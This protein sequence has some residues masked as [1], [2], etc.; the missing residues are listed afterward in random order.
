MSAD[1]NLNTSSF[2]KLSDN[3]DSL[4]IELSDAGIQFCEYN[5]AQ[6]T[7]LY[8]VDYPVENTISQSL[9]EHL[10]G[11][12]K[13]FQF[14]KKKYT[15]VL[16]NYFDKQFTMC[17]TVFYDLES[18]RSMLEFNV[19]RI[20]N[21]VILTDDINA[22]IKLVYSVDE[23]LKSTLDQL[24]PNHQLKHSLTVLSKLMLSTEEFVRENILLSIHSNY[25]EVVLKQDQKLILANQFAIKTQEDVLYYVLFIL[26][27]YQLNPSSVALSIAGNI[28][29]NS[30]LLTSIK[31]YI[32]NI[33]LVKG[34]KS[35][36]WTDVQGMPQHFNYSLLNRLFCE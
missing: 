1:I 13:H 27:Q 31:K 16:I 2:G 34:H 32:K 36:N 28:D 21:K 22:E 10:V 17:P 18:S 6:N 30:A 35:L 20:E 14:S 26:E 4:I 3:A 19:G 15:H 8:V 33:R 11:A 9:S 5:V 7:P 25:I 24:F 23:H 12:I 29:S